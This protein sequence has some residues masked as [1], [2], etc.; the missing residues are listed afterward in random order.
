MIR[1]IRREAFPACA[2]LIRKSFQT[3]ADESGRTRKNMP[4]FTVF[5]TAEERLIR[6][7]DGGRRRV[8]EN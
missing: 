4:R 1:E 5:A 8:Y 7:K 2:D 6:H 3:A